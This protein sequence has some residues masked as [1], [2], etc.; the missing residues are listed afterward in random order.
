MAGVKAKP[1]RSQDLSLLPD[2]NIEAYTYDDKYIEQVKKWIAFWREYPFRFCSDYIGI[3]LKPFQ[4]ILIYQMMKNDFTM[5]IASRGIGKTW[6]T[7]V[8]CIVRCILYP[9]TRVQV[10]SETRAQAYELIKKIKDLRDQYPILKLEIKYVS[11]G[12]GDPIVMFA[13]GSTIET[14]VSS[15]TGRSRRAH[16]LIVDEFIKVKQ[17]IYTSVLR[18]FKSD[19]RNPLY[20]ENPEYAHLRESNKEILMSS[21]GF[22]SE[23]YYAKYVAFLK[24]MLKGKSYFVCNLSYHIGVKEGVKMIE[25]IINEMTEDDFDPVKWDMEMNGKFLGESQDAFFDR[26]EIVSCRRLGKAVYPFDV[27]QKCNEKDVKYLTVPKEKN[28][29]RIVFADIALM[30][31]RK[32]QNDASC[33]GLMRLFPNTHGDDYIREVAYL[34]SCSGIVTDVQA[35]RIRKLFKDFD[36]DYIVMD[37]RGVGAPVADLIMATTLVDKETG[38]QY[39]PLGATDDKLHEDRCSNMNAPRVLYAF[40]GTDNRNEQMAIRLLNAIQSKK[41]RFLKDENVVVAETISRLKGYDEYSTNLKV[42]LKDPFLQTSFAVHE[43]LN[44]EGDRSSRKIKIKE[45]SGRKDRY[46]GIAMA[47]YYASELA[48]KNLR[49][50]NRFWK[51]ED[52]EEDEVL[53]VYMA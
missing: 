22:K 21:A 2:I 10:A 24:Q 26:D 51:D 35:T 43:M 3:N 17:D 19:P 40:V 7:A 36:A 30:K 46:S 27:I 12:K 6:L 49:K 34:E 47:N 9:K 37:Y 8:F 44:L 20:L 25:E 23:W 29:I 38:E 48:H 16:I 4:R 18:K 15:E 45:M 39:E 52:D 5:F 32:H 41:I 53:G 31:S 28:E 50:S 33:F 13:S 1:K 42:K 14:T 11:E